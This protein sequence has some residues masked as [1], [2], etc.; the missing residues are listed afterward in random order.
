MTVGRFL[1]KRSIRKKLECPN[2]NSVI[3]RQPVHAP[4]SKHQT[5]E[6]SECHACEEKVLLWRPRHR[7]PGGQLSMSK[8]SSNFIELTHPRDSERELKLLIAPAGFA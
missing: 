4:I 7:A 3:V 5:D 8:V 2:Q 6:Q 1:E